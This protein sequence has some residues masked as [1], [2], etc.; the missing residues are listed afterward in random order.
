MPKIVSKRIVKPALDP[1]FAGDLFDKV[2]GFAGYGFN[3]SHSC[4]YTLISYQCMWLK[5]H[6]PVEFFAAALTILDEE[7]KTTLLKDA[8]LYGI[9]VETPTINIS[10]N[11][12][13]IITDTRLAMPLQ[14]VLGISEKS[15]TAIME[16]RVKA[17]GKFT[18]K[19]HFLANVEKRKCNSRVQDILDRIGSF[20][21]IEPGQKRPDDPSRIRDHYHE[22]GGCQAEIR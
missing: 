16:A 21:W 10:T 20:A 22:S 7:K 17:G 1:V 11:R 13:E 14:V 18:D 5:V 19:A 4:E 9:T 12:F 6:Y 3:K 15:A 2:E 8:K